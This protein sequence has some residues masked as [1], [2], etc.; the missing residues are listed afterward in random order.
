M[1]LA[2]QLVEEIFQ[3]VKDLNEKRCDL[4]LAEQ[5]TNVALQYAHYGYILNRAALLWMDP[6]LNCAKIQM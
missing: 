5:N 6:R 4:L 3:I 2:P 1:G